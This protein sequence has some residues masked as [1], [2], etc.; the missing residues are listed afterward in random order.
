MIF[1]FYRTS[2]TVN[3]TAFNFVFELPS[4]Y[5]LVQNVHYSLIFFFPNRRI[6]HHYV[7]LCIAYC[8]CQFEFTVYSKSNVALYVYR[9]KNN[10]E[11][12]HFLKKIF[13]FRIARLPCETYWI[14]TP[15]HF[16]LFHLYTVDEMNV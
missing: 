11:H 5:T 15:G 16:Y 3:V 8:G 12:R 14:T 2:R 7:T 9:F 1:M 4:T 6:V 13:W 10:S